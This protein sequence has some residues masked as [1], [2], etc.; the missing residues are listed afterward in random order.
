MKY[1]VL[2]LCALTLVL[3]LLTACGGDTPPAPPP[4]PP[5][6][7][8][9]LTL[10]PSEIAL[11][12]ERV[13]RLSATRSAE[14]RA[15]VAGIVQERSYVEGSDVAEGDVLFRI[16]PSELQASL[17]SA[18][19]AL[20]Q[21]RAN[22]QNAQSKAQR[23][24][25]LAGKGVIARQDLD[26]AQANWNSLAA[27]VKQ[28]Q[29]QVQQAELD[30]AYATVTAP[31][32]GRAGQAQVTEGALVG[33]GAT[34]L[35]TTIEQID[36]IYVNFGQTQ[37]EFEALRA[38]S[39]QTE[40]RDS[41]ASVTLRLRGGTLYPHAGQI[42]FADL[43]VDPQTGAIALRATVPNPDA[44]L[45]PGMF[46]DVLLTHGQRSAAFRVPQTAVQRDAQGAYVLN[47]GAD[48]KVERRTLTL[49]QMSGSDWIVSEGLSAGE[50]IV[51]SGV[52]KARPGAVVKPREILAAAPVTPAPEPEA[53]ASATPPS[54]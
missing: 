27:A 54:N 9:V 8:D 7:V 40:Q 11:T 35:L 19:A 13:G 52:Q 5:A 26:D 17:N 39:D 37:A 3:A 38:L 14:V 23:F 48:D 20:A 25:E 46:V 15:R 36:P 18:R 31:I 6:E 34:T 22:A 1:P 47:V 43:A 44:L 32:S 33:Q 30:L 28:A 50:R 24:Q 4:P 45:L 21:A 2:A 29:A 51:V 41:D 10:M 53:S 42:S 16:D 49:Q 12:S